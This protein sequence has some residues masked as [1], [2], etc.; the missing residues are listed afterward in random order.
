MEIVWY[1]YYLV[2]TFVPCRGWWS[3]WTHCLKTGMWGC[4]VSMTMRR[5]VQF[6]VEHC[7]ALI[8]HIEDGLVIA[9]WKISCT[10]YLPRLPPC[11]GGVNEHTGSPV[12]HHWVGPQENQCW[13]VDIAE[14]LYYPKSAE[15]IILSSMPY[16]LELCIVLPNLYEFEYFLGIIVSPI[17]LLKPLNWVIWLAFGPRVGLVRV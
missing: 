3:P 11:V 16:L 4:F 2:V 1:V 15:H 8:H 13:W 9:S 5:F 12:L 6:E 17:L 10:L 7:V 14:S